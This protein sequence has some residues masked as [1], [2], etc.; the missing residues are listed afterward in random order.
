[1]CRST[2]VFCCLLTHL[3]SL[4]HFTAFLLF[5]CY[6]I[7]TVV[8]ELCSSY[9]VSMVCAAARSLFVCFYI[10]GDLTVCDLSVLACVCL[11]VWVSVSVRACVSVCYTA[12][13]VL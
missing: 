2:L 13:K 7:G 11:S 9:S 3:H 12:V 10:R 6:K 5:W 8:T 1:M 4:F